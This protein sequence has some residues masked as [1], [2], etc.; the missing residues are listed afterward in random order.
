[1]ECFEDVVKWVLTWIGDIDVRILMEIAIAV[2]GAWTRLSDAFRAVLTA[3]SVC[4]SK[5]T[6]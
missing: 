1:M 3:G 6:S 2:V 4:Y 5:T